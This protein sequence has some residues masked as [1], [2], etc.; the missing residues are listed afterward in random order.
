MKISMIAAIAENNVIGKNNDMIWHL[1]DDMQYFMQKT[2][3][4]HVIMGRKNFESL[5]PK[6]R[7]LPNRTNI[8]ITRQDDYEAEGA[9]VVNSLEEALEIA[10][11]NGENEA[12]IIGGG[13]IYNLGLGVAHIMYLTEIHEVFEGDAYFPEFDKLKWKEVERLP[14]PV[15]HKHKYPFDFV[16]YK[17]A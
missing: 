10:E 16:L 1:P 7:P 6:Y 2:T 9:L 14:H 15:D 13:Q 5:P 4:H 3:G 12:F 11:K 8:I 17:R